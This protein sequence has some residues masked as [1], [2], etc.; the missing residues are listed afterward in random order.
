MKALF[1]ITFVTLLFIGLNNSALAQRSDYSRN[2]NK[3]RG[4]DT[5]LIKYQTK[6]DEFISAIGDEDVS[7]ARKIK[8][9]I[10]KIMKDEIQLN[11]EKNREEQRRLSRSSQNYS[12]ETKEQNRRVRRDRNRVWQRSKYTK[13]ESY[14]NYSTAQLLEKQIEI[15]KKLQDLYLETTQ[16]YWKRAREHENLMYEFERT[17][18]RR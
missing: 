16:N 3:Q 17:L 6:V 14:S 8:A 1:K 4:D 18:K 12:T 13:R 2:F 9:D 15:T 7:S 11:H 10:L 5:V